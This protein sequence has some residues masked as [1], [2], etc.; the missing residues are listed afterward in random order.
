MKRFCVLILAAISPISGLSGQEA[1]P[2]FAFRGKTAVVQAAG[3]TEASGAA[4]SRRVDDAVWVINDSGGTPQ[5]H[6]LGTDGAD[7]GAVTVEGVKNIDWEDLASY[8]SGGVARLLIAD[9]GDNNARRPHVSLLIV[10]EP[11]IPGGGKPVAGSVK[12][13]RRIDFRFEGGP[14]DCEAVA[15]DAARQRVLLLTKRT[16]PPELHELPLAPKTTAGALPVTR[17]IGTVTLPPPTRLRIAFATQ[18][19]AMDIS[20]DGSAVAVLTYVGVFLFQRA[21]GQSWQ[22]AM[23]APVALGPHLLPQAEAIAFS[24]DGSSI[25]VLSEG[26]KQPLMSYGR[27]R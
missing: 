23:A 20:A 10:R 21:E 9:T 17:K 1:A 6:L 27:S 4:A 16:S 8:T 25:F 18:P 5:L 15:V 24:R 11:V 22:A 14:R 2:P 26:K 12:V 3:I 19:T 7:R 13:E